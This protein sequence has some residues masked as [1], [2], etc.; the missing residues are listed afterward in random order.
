M[1]ILTRTISLQGSRWTWCWREEMGVIPYPSENEL[2]AYVLASLGLSCSIKFWRMRYHPRLFPPARSPINKYF[3]IKKV[4]ARDEKI[5]NPKILLDMDKASPPRSLDI[6]NVQV[7]LQL[8][9]YRMM[10]LV[11]WMMCLVISGRRGTE[12]SRTT[13]KSKGIKGR[14]RGREWKRERARG[15]ERKRARERA[16]AIEKE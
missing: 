7:R 12:G 14:E 5:G 13:W 16:H 3:Q 2:W 11:I 15:R 6:R 4:H 10:C 8:L 9:H 1:S